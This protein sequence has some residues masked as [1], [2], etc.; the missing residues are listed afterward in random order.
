M[1]LLAGGLVFLAGAALGLVAVA[2]R[3]VG[4]GL[5]LLFLP[6]VGLLALVGGVVFVTM[7]FALGPAIVMGVVGG[8]ILLG[9]G[10]LV[11]VSILSW[12]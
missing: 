9:L 7:F 10:A 6:F 5:K 2:A 4:F 1:A 12:L 11:I 3:I 8:A